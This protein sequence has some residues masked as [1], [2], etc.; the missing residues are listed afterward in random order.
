MR[1]EIKYFRMELTLAEKPK[2]MSTNMLRACMSC[3]RVL[4]GTGGGGDYL[5]EGCLYEIRTGVVRKY[6]HSL[7]G[8]ID[9]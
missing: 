6:K 5:C 8:G 1:E 7:I 4:S 2:G 9:E 3:N